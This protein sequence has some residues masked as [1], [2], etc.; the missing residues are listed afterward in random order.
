VK[1][2]LSL[3]SGLDA[4]LAGAIAADNEDMDFA[5]AIAPEDDQLPDLVNAKLF[6]RGRGGVNG[7]S[8]IPLWVTREIAQ[9]RAHHAALLVAV[10][11]RRMQMRRT[12]IVPITSA[13]W[14]ELAS[15][16]RRE[17]ETILKHLRLISG[18]LKLEERHRGYTRYQAT[19]GDM[20]TAAS[21]EGEDG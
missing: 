14:A 11:L 17:R 20:W 10:I 9:V 15:P 19:K 4:G 3:D 7:Y 1:K 21:K 16:N 18:V 2:P 12:S 5:S 13:I 6:T 8:I